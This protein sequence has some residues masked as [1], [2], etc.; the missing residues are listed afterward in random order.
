[1][2]TVEKGGQAKHDVPHVHYRED[3]SI[4]YV[5]TLFMVWKVRIKYVVS[6][7]YTF[8]LIFLELQNLKLSGSPLRDIA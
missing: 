7:A 1:M 2:T 3:S 8:S 5:P 6:L 4:Y